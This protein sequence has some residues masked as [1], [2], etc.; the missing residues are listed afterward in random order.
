M[1]RTGTV[2]VPPR[3]SLFEPTLRAR[4][5]T[6]ARYLKERADFRLAIEQH[7]IEWDERFPQFAIGKPASPPNVRLD[8]PDSF[9]IVYPAP[10]E[11]AVARLDVHLT[12]ASWDADDHKAAQARHSWRR[13]TTQLAE[14]WW[15]EQHFPMWRT[16]TGDLPAV[17]FVAACLLWRVELV[18]EEWIAREQ[19]LMVSMLPPDA[20]SGTIGEFSYWSTYART[21]NAAL[22]NLQLDEYLSVADLHQLRQHADT[23]ARAAIR[24]VRGSDRRTWTHMVR[25]I[26]G[27]TTT[28][29]REMEQQVMQIHDFLYGAS[30][31]RV[32]AQRLYAQGM[33]PYR[34]A[35]ELGISDRHAIRILKDED[36]D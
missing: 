36:T 2:A 22:D 26:P 7:R 3:R 5:V 29:W 1:D 15:P 32:L 24:A 25:L 12:S 9:V 27:M 31:V 14:T 23:A 13:L 11:E 8:S 10:L 33:T 6:R 21:L 18:P 35:R 34:I 30:P 28:D 19:A 4:Y 17:P 16:F 20:E